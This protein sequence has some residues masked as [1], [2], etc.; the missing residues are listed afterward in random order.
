MLAQWCALQRWGLV[1]GSDA[2]VFH[3]VLLKSLHLLG[4]LEGPGESEVLGDVLK[5]RRAE[6][7]LAFQ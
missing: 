2:G 4:P 5:H 6:L 3:G 7:L 1:P